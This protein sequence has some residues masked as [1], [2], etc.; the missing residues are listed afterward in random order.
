MS[1]SIFL[2]T[3]DDKDRILSLME[4]CHDETG[5]RS[6]PDLRDLTVSTL[7]EDNHHGAIWLIGPQ[8]A[9]LG[10]VVV[11][12]CWSVARAGLEGWVDETFIRPSVRNRGIGTEV[13]HAVAVALGQGGVRALHARVPKTNPGMIKFCEKVGFKAQD[14]TLLLTDPL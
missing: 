12:F 7:L 9:P 10:Y 5:Q 13:L 4:R 3:P 14:G 8:R 11:T 2:A 1:A 6:D